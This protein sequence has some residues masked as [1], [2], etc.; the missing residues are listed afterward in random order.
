VLV[1]PDNIVR[2]FE[3]LAALQV[4]P[5]IVTRRHLEL[6]LDFIR[7]VT[8]AAERK[9]TSGRFGQSAG[10][11][12]VL[13]FW[14]RCSVLRLPLGIGARTTK[15]LP[16]EAP[17]RRIANQSTA[18]CTRLVCTA[19]SLQGTAAITVR[20]FLHLRTRRRL[21]LRRIV[22]RSERR[23]TSRLSEAELSKV[24]QR[25]HS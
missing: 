20:R 24:K 21:L 10:L 6:G 11:V 12:P 14:R 15:L 2:H 16:S 1:P 18:C 4:E 7:A 3:P 17:T 5:F 19:A 22:V 25:W 13:N 8:A 23:T 9:L